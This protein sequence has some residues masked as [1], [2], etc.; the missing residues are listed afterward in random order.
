MAGYHDM[1]TQRSGERETRPTYAELSSQVERLASGCRHSGGGRR[2]EIAGS[3]W[4]RRRDLLMPNGADVE[5][6][7]TCGEERPPKS[8]VLESQFICELED[9]VDAEKSSPQSTIGHCRPR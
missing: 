6:E 8:C 2:E 7:P 3:M 1:Y 5:D 4:L 9:G